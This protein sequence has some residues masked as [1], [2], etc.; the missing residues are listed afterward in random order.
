MYAGSEQ[1]VPPIFAPDPIQNIYLDVM[2][3]GSEQMVLPILAP[4][5]SH[6]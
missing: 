4:G 5:P 6:R 1:M 3:A 2:Y